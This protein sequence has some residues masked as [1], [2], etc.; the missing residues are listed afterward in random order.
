MAEVADGGKMAL[1]ILTSPGLVVDSP[2]VVVAPSQVIPSVGNGQDKILIFQNGLL[3]TMLQ[4]AQQEELLIL[5]V[6][7]HH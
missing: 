3:M 2:P 6:L 4:E 1:P 7:I 5:Q